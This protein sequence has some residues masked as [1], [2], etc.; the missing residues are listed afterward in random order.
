MG[1]MENNLTLSSTE[2]RAL[3]LL[4][5]GVSA[6]QTAAALGIS[7]SRVSQLLSEES[8][9]AAVSERRFAALSKHTARDNA[10]DQIEDALI[11][12]FRD[13]IPLMYKPME[14]M[15]AMQVVN[16]AKRRGQS[17]PESISNQREVINLILPTQIIQQFQV[18]IKNQVIQ[19]GQQT[20]VTVQSGSMTDLLAKHK[21]K[22]L[23]HVK[24]LP[25]ATEATAISGG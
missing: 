21:E 1:M 17:A 23:E 19:A 18:D 15:K 7:P 6:E 9:A 25:P 8:F 5:Q 12:K 24:L 22:D 20:L 10:Y 4:G 16:Q 14:V 11:D 3:D 2:Q 13:M